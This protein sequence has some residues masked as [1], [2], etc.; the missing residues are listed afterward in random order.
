MKEYL[1]NQKILRKKRKIKILFLF[2]MTIFII[3]YSFN[4]FASGTDGLRLFTGTE[5]ILNDLTTYLLV[6]I[7]VIGI[8]VGLYNAVKMIS[9]DT[10]EQMQTKKKI[11]MILIICIVAESADALLKWILSYY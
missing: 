7:P 1:K 9:Q 2:L 3:I 8:V 6:I 10:Q 11:K 4:V 5:S